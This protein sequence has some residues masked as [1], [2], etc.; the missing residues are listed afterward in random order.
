MN[1]KHIAIGLFITFILSILSQSLDSDARSRR[2]SKRSSYSSRS[3]SRSHSSRRCTSCRRNSAGKIKRSSSAR[4][5]FKKRTGHPKG[6]KGY[7]IHHN[8]PLY[9]GGSDTPS[10]MRW[11][12]KEEHK[13]LH[14]KR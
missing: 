2:R 7:V 1:K 8:T 5:T 11:V 6:R 10:N 13:R 14:R 12:S 3:Y 9:K 4:T